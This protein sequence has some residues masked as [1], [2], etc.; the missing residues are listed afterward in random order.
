[1][2]AALASQL[3]PPG[4]KQ[5]IAAA[6]PGGGAVAA[7]DTLVTAP[8]VK[9]TAVATAADS[10]TLPFTM[11][12]DTIFIQNQ[13]AASMTVWGYG[14]ASI[15]GGASLAHGNGLGALYVSSLEGTWTRFLQ[16]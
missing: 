14:G 15:N 16:S 12:G 10:I 13:G 7:G 6:K 3:P 5:I 9:V 8:Y 1:M 11:G 4:P 2:V